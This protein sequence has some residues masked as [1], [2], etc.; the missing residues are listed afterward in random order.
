MPLT[1]ARRRA[2]SILRNHPKGLTA[3]EFGDLMWPNSPAHTRVYN[4]G[5]NASTTGMG[6]WLAAGSYLA[7]LRRAG[8]TAHH[9]YMNTTR[10][11]FISQDGRAAL[12]STEEGQV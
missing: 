8:L 3:S 12:E 1:D 7:K 2:L 10:L 4:C 11:N 6:V 5:P 9:W